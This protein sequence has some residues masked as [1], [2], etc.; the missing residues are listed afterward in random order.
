ME[1]IRYKD[2]NIYLKILVTYGFMSLIANAMMFV[3]GV[4]M[5]LSEGI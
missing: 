2:L 5:A 3:L 4:L 1:K